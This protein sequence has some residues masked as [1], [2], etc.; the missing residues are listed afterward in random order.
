MTIPI[1]CLVAFALL[2][3]VVVLKAE[4]DGLKQENRK[5]KNALGDKLL[6]LSSG[7]EISQGRRLSSS[8]VSHV[9]KAS[10]HTAVKR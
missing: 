4:V 10:G 8:E 5:L 7:L 9:D 1:L 3:W 6:N 2:A